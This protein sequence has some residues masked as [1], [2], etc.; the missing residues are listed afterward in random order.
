MDIYLSQESLVSYILLKDLP[1]CPKGRIFKPCKAANS[2]GKP[3][4]YFPSLS[5]EEV[6]SGNLELYKIQ[7]IFV[8]NNPEW[9]LA[10]Q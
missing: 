8:E 6:L 1:G 5:D 9:F 10:N 2:Q 4:Y 3:V 7:S